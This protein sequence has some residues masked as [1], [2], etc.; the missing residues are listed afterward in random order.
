MSLI[1][2]RTFELWKN[3]MPH[4]NNIANRV[5]TD[6]YCVQ[7]YS[8]LVNYSQ[9]SPLMIFEKWAAVEVSSVR[10]VPEGM[11]T[12]T[13][14]QGLYAVFL[15]RG[16]SADFRETAHYIYEEWLPASD[17]I[18]DHRPHFEILGDKYKREE[19]DSEEEIFIPVI[20]KE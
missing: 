15:H 8:E 20:K 7:V 12:L 13:I 14:T 3:F 5:S 1:E 17:Y 4:R 11:E 18:I 10:D 2:N 16:T 6:L 9:Y 19:S